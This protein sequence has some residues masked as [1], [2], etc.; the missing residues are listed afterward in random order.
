M[1]AIQN[2]SNFLFGSGCAGLGN[3]S[4]K[5]P[6]GPPCGRRGGSHDEFAFQFVVG[7]VFS[8]G[9]AHSEKG[10]RP[11]YHCQ[12][13]PLISEALHQGARGEPGGVVGGGGGGEVHRGAGGAPPSAPWACGPPMG[14][15]IPVVG[16]P[17]VSGGP[18][19]SRR[20][21][22]PA[23]AGMTATGDFRQS[24][25]LPGRVSK[26]SR[27]LWGGVRRTIRMGLTVVGRAFGVSTCF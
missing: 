22:I 19:Q 3:Y 23:F 10:P 13:C 14:M 18:G 20:G 16:H 12:D 26:V 25:K 5:Y 24:D 8:Q 11:G 6:T 15:E 2:R 4:F 17:R 7:F 1:R 9:K 27:D 21:W